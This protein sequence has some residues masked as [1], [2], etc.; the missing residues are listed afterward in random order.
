[1][2]RML[3]ALA[4]IGQSNG[5]LSSSSGRSIPGS[6]HSKPSPRRRHGQRSHQSAL[7]V[8]PI[9]SAIASPVGSVGILAFVVVIHELGHYSLAKRLGIEVE[10]FSVGFGPKV[11]GFRARGDEFSLRAIPLGGYV[12]FPENYNATLARELQKEDIREQAEFIGASEKSVGW[13]IVNILAIGLLEDREWE[14]EKRR[15]KQEEEEISDKERNSL[16][17][18]LFRRQNKVKADNDA[19]TIYYENPNLLQNR[20]WSQRAQVVSG[21]VLFNLLL[22]F[23]IVFG[24]VNFG[25]GI[26]VPKV[27]DGIL[28]TAQPAPDAPS[29]NVLSKGD[30]IVGVNGATIGPFAAAPDQAVYESR[31]SIDE[32]ITKVRNTDDGGSLSLSVREGGGEKIRKVK[33]TPKRQQSSGPQTIGVMLAPN[34][35]GT[36]VIKTR[37]PVEAARLAGKFVSN[38]SV[39]TANGLLGAFSSLLKGAGTSQLSGPVGLIQ[40]GSTVVSTQNWSVVLLFAATISVNLA[41]LNSLPFPALDGGQLVFILAEAVS[42]RKVDQQLQEGLTGTAVLVLLA[43]SVALFAGDISSLLK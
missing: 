22:S 25:P 14:A 33:V 39:Q 28:V 17:G 21:G 8:S 26:S 36:D 29:R 13:K 41:V 11:F 5:F 42:G 2:H 18:R 24:Q 27:S 31:K 43:L 40:E 30:V 6:M 1:M 10:E 16:F 38:L 4:W 23:T 35:V 32:F 9:V 20:P 19:S 3:I 15:R 34:V 12:R 7:M 37:N